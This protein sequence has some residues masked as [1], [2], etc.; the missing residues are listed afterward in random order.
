MELSRPTGQRPKGKT[1]T[2]KTWWDLLRNVRKGGWGDPM[3]YAFLAP[4]LLLFITFQVWVIIRGF[5]MS[6]TDFRFLRQLEGPAPFVGVG[7]FI[8]FLTD[9]TYFWPSL[10]RALYFTFIYMP[11]MLGSAILFS[12]VIAKV[13]SSFIAAFYRT[14]MYLPVIL[15]TAVAILMWQVL[16]NNQTGYVNHIL[17]NVLGMP[18]LAL[19]WLGRPDTALPMVA[20]TR[21]WKDA[22]YSAMLFL[23]GMYNINDELYEAASIDG[24]TGLQQWWSITL[25]LLKPV[26]ILVL[27]L[28][29]NLVSAAQDFMIMFGPGNFG[30]QGSG[31]TL[32]YY[33]WMVAFRFGDLRMGYAAA[34]SLFLGVLSALLSGI[35]FKVMRTERA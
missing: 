20:L 29:A 1:Q 7:N 8:Q 12:S 4:G 19:N 21:V 26:I 28:N 17:R 11:L 32:G 10:W 23:I 33:I 15:P 34:M 22:G 6:F 2:L 35:V 27:V 18:Q 16:L 31:L 24:A 14:I 13:K 5:T 3:G 30:P 9:D 25:P